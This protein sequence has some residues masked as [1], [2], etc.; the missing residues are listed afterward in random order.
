MRDRMAVTERLLEQKL[1][2]TAAD[3]DRFTPDAAFGAEL[4]IL[5][6]RV[7]GAV[8]G[9]PVAAGDDTVDT[10]LRRA[11]LHA[12]VERRGLS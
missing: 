7:V 12:A 9:A 11:G 3:I 2:L 8:V 4:Q 1:G 5:R 10:I 6:D